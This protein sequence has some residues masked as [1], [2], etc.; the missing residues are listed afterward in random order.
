MHFQIL[1]Q[2][3][4]ST[5]ASPAGY[6]PGPL[7]VGKMLAQH[8]KTETALPQGIMGLLQIPPHHHDL[9]DLGLHRD[10][11]TRTFSPAKTKRQVP[12]L[13]SLFKNKQ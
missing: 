5:F 12:H 8:S 9:Q 1:F 6:M 10:A 7:V 2:H 3:F 4:C 13:Y 11:V